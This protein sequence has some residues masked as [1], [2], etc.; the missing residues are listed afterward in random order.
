MRRTKLLVGV[1]ATA[2]ALMAVVGCSSG[3]ASTAPS[4]S[5]TSSTGA[6]SDASAEVAKVLAASYIGTFRALPASSP[7]PVRGKSV[8]VVTL[9]SKSPS[10]ANIAAGVK[11]AGALLGW[12][13]TVFDGQANPTVWNDGVRQAIAA[14]ADAIVLDVVECA[15]V[16]ATLQQAKK[17]GIKIFGG[18]GSDCGSTGAGANL[19]DASTYENYPGGRS[20]VNKQT[21]KARAAWIASKA[22][23]EGAGVLEFTEPDYAALNEPTKEFEKALA[24][25]CPKCQ[26]HTAPF[27]LTDLGTQLRAKVEASL[28]KY[29]KDTFVAFPY[30][31]AVL[32]GGSAAI[33]SSPH[34][35]DIQV[36]GGE[37][38]AP[39]VEII[40]AGAGQN[41]CVGTPY[42]WVGWASVDAL[43]R[44][45]NNEPQVDEGI[46]VQLIDAGHNLPAA[47][48]TYDG[49]G[50]YQSNF[51]KIWGVS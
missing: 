34:R 39:N 25:Y 50:D 43:N 2:A 12:K 10:V 30:D 8:W 1:G 33:Q 13:T 15:P 24:T 28:L 51:K 3:D 46:G 7:K 6:S 20:G 41:A 45:F 16:Q 38:L 4:A 31:S 22:G 18:V 40:R 32:L 19:F 23:P 44:A 26:L 17:A 21:A 11:E 29:P 47:G 5:R 9:T 27:N 14:K 37:C 42:P 48:V 49:V 36:M 35:A